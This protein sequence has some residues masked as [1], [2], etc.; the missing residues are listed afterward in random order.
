MRWHVKVMGVVLTMVAAAVVT[1]AQGGG[2][3]GPALARF[4]APPE[5]VVAIRAGRLFDS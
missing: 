5:Q 3:G 4:L 1:M 2:G